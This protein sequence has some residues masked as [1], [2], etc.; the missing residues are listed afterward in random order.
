MK[1]LIV[2]ALLVLFAA[3]ASADTAFQFTVP[4]SRMPDDP[5]VSGF[6]LSLLHGQADSMK[7]FDF[8][9]VSFSQSNDFAGAGPFFA[10]AQVTG[11]SSG[12][13]CSFVN[14]VGGESTG[15]VGGFINISKTMRSGAVVGF[16]NITEGYSNVDVSGLAISDKSKVQV[17]FV[18]ITQEIESVQIGFLNMAS[19]GIF[20]IMPF[21][22]APKK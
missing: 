4:G 8:G 3:T 17:G 5:N 1:R 14:V 19:N 11:D 12:C 20:P 15:V 21:F 10:V 16:L 6:R 9:M 13:L 2:S 7:G 22:N 18:N